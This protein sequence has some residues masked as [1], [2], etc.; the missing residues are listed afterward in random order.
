MV[1]N[2]NSVT[3]EEIKAAVADAVLEGDIVAAKTRLILW[4]DLITEEGFKSSQDITDYY[5]AKH[6][7]D[8]LYK[9]DM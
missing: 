3:V 7:I 1:F 5:N 8:S 4:E 2:M 6:L 9:G